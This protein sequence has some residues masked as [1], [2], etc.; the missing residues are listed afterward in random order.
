MPVFSNDRFG[1]LRLPTEAEW[2]YAARGGHRVTDLQMNSEDFFPT[3][4][5]D[6]ADFAVF[7]DT[8]AAKPPE[9]L[10]WIGTKCANPLG[11][12]D[13]A[14]NA[15][16]MVLDPFSFAVGFR[17][18][19]AVGGGIIKGGSYRRERNEI[20][21]GRREELPLFLKNGAFRSGDVGFRVVL[22]GIV[23]PEDRQVSLNREWAELGQQGHSHED[24]RRPAGVILEMDQSKDPIAEI[25]RLLAA[26]GEAAEKKNLLFLREVLKQNRILLEAQKGEAIKGMIRSALFTGESILNYAIRRQVVLN[27][28]NRLEKMKSETISPSVRESLENTIAKA[29]DTVHMLDNAIDR[30]VK[31]YLNRIK[32]SQT[33]PEDIF[34]NQLA[35]VSQELEMEG[36]FSQSLKTRLDVYKKHIDLYKNNSG[37]INPVIIREDLMVAKPF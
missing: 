10:A 1:Y 13:T 37:S 35:L 15:A 36:G 30:F 6:L 22:S 5:R 11:L 29:V 21:P 32:E 20:M 34:E 12:Y 3:N 19:G 31:F 4:E 33:Y 26:S 24:D 8:E 18:H 17:R 28:I 27:E 14:G 23:T 2:E 16:E 25:D 9:K 7:T